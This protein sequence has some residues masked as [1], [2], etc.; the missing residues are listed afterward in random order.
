MTKYAVFTMDVEDFADIY[1]LRKKNKERY[2]SMMDGFVAYLDL[3]DKYQIKADFFVLADR[4]EKDRQF[5]EE[6]LKRGHNLALHGLHHEL[7]SNETN[8][9]FVTQ[10][11]EA[12]RLVEE[13]FAIKIQGFRAPG[14][15]VRQDEIERLPSLGFLYDASQ[16]NYRLG[17]FGAQFDTSSFKSVREGILIHDGLY[18]ITMPQSEV[19]PLKGLPIGGGAYCRI[20]PHRFVKHVVEKTIKRTD[21]YVFYCHPFELSQIKIPHVGILGPLNYVYLHHRKGFM[22]RIEEIIAFLRKDNYEF[23]TYEELLKRIEA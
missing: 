4:I 16:Q 13:A 11:T 2:P 18:E 14:F 21:L 8:E 23:V 7:P 5:L 3:L 1:C 20:P 6:A 19:H 12:K 10:I 15:S 9:E 22:R 17:T